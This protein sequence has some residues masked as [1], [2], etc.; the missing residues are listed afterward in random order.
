MVTKDEL[1]HL[2]KLAKVLQ[3]RISRFMYDHVVRDISGKLDTAAGTEVYLNGERQHGPLERFYYN[4]YDSFIRS[5]KWAADEDLMRALRRVVETV[6]ATAID[7]PH[8]KT[9]A[10]LVFRLD[11]L[12]DE[13]SPG[14]A[15]AVTRVNIDGQD[16]ILPAAQWQ[17]ILRN[18][19]AEQYIEAFNS[20]VDDQSIFF[21]ADT[22]RTLPN[23]VWNANGQMALL[24]TGRGVLRGRYTQAAYDRHIRDVVLRLV[25]AVERARISPEVKNGLYQKVADK[26]RDYGQGYREE[27][28]RFIQVFDVQ[29]RSTEELRV[30]LAQMSS[31]R[32][33]FND[34]VVTVDKNV[35]LDSTGHP[36]LEPMQGALAE[37]EAWRKVVDGGAGAEIAKY[38][39][40]LG[41]LLLDLGPNADK[42]ASAAPA[43]TGAAPSAP[44]AGGSDKVDTET[45]IQAIG[46]AGKRY[47]AELRGEVGSYTF[48]VESWLTSNVIPDDERK[49]F[50]APLRRLAELGRVDID[51]IVWRV[52]QTEMYPDVQKV[53][54]LF[55]FNPAAKEEATPQM[56]KDL[57][58]PQEGRFFDFFRRYIEPLA[59]ASPGDRPPY[60][61][62]GGAQRSLSLPPNMFPA[63]NAAA[64]LSSRLW[65][66]Q[67][68]NPTPLELKIATV[69]F[70]REL[71]QRA[72]QNTAVTL[73]YLNIGDGSVFDFNQKP[74]LISVGFEWNKDS[75]S[76]VGVQL[77]D[78]GSKENNFPPPIVSN[79]QYWSFYHLLRLGR[80]S[81]VKSPPSARLYTWDIPSQRDNTPNDVL[82]VK[83]VTVNDPW[84]PFAP[85]GR[86]GWRLR[87]VPRPKGVR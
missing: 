64:L 2:Q 72:A 58:H 75:E 1:H 28:R 18:S 11:Q 73:T 30:V 20:S 80:P 53:A 27:V 29:A 39:S 87:E 32:S 63:I 68:G 6:N 41:Q 24:F 44:P 78:L 82:P 10:E 71:K 79:G 70:D 36:M 38:K 17:D 37:F 7:V 21:D 31:D 77:T 66:Q 50:L 14:D 4:K 33:P 85:L 57:F 69:P 52:W 35:R 60:R 25:G 65:D 48:I 54:V 55:P 34:F 43:A 49:P 16:K 42:P 86:F 61:P 76:Q 45:L 12:N 3:P 9:L 40:T 51:K 5:T 46:P 83:F 22:E 84:E 56:L 23:V 59:F 74:S 13:P 19:K 62:R 15:G 8:P 81:G 67:T 47:L 26:V